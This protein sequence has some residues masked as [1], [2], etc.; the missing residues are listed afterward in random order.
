[1]MVVDDAAA[2]SL[3]TPPKTSAQSIFTNFP[4]D[5]YKWGYI[6]NTERYCYMGNNQYG[7]EA[8]LAG[9]GISADRRHWRCYT[10]HHGNPYGQQ[11]VNDQRYVVDGRT[12][13]VS[14]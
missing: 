12:Y 1:M 13:R 7:M 8:A 3:L 6:V 9:M 11:V 14:V 4:A 10:A 2:G 5:L